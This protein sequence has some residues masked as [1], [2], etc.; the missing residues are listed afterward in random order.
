MCK[1]CKNNPYNQVEEDE[2]TKESG[3][4]REKEKES[5]IRKL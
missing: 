5:T 3:E 2:V 4:G 1:I